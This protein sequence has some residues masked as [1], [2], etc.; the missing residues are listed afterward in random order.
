MNISL[1]NKYENIYGKAFSAHIS[2]TYWAGTLT[3]ASGMFNEHTDD[4]QTGSGWDVPDR[5][6]VV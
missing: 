5:K 6:S 1:F 2:N 3:D 4:Y